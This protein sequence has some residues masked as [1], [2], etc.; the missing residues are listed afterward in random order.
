[1]LWADVTLREQPPD[2]EDFAAIAGQ[3]TNK[4]EVPNSRE[5]FTFGGDGAMQYVQEFDAGGKPLRYTSQREVLEAGH[6]ALGFYTTTFDRGDGVRVT[7]QFVV[8]ETA[9]G[10]ELDVSGYLSGTY[11]RQ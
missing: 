9:A 1:M 5:T 2:P 6:E 7:V 8:Y 10:P 3:W 4:F 11:I